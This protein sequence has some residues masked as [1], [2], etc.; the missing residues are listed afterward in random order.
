MTFIRRRIVHLVAV[1]ILVTVGSFMLIHILPGDPTISILGPGA[2]AQ[3]RAQLRSELRLDD[4]I[5]LQYVRWVSHVFTGDLGRSYVNRQPVLEA[6]RQRLPVTLELL[7]LSQL[8]ALVIAVPLAVMAAQRPN[9]LLDRV[10]TS[11]AFGFLSVPSFMLAVILVYLLAVNWKIFPATGY[12]PFGRNPFENLRGMTLPVVTLAVPELAVYLRL[13]RTDMIATLQE[14]FIT[15]A[16]AKGLS[17]SRILLR[18]AFRPS[19]FSLITV[20]GLNFGRL[21]GG[22]FVIE[23]IYAL[24]G[25]GSLAVIG[26]YQRDYL[27]VQSTVVVVAVGYVV[28][29]FLVDMLYVALDPR[30]RHVRALA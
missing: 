26:I 4:P 21:V 18:H 6:L 2:T 17:T 10:S 25:I 19:V 23:V 29:N 28:V 3:G 20:A 14:D 11:T 12:V 27:L 22:A 30:I 1:L 9:G 5:P 8:L 16:R 13:L 24:P 7:L 15:M